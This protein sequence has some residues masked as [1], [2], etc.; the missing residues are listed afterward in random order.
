MLRCCQHAENNFAWI[1]FKRERPVNAGGSRGDSA[2]S[3]ISASGSRDENVTSKISAGGSGVDSI[4]SK[5][6]RM[7]KDVREVKH[8]EVG[9]QRKQFYDPVLDETAGKTKDLSR[10][11]SDIVGGC[12]TL[13]RFKIWT[14]TRPWLSLKNNLITCSYCS[15]VLQLGVFKDPGQRIDPAFINGIKAKT[16]KKLNDKIGDHSRAKTHV[17][18]ESIII[19]SREKRAIENSLAISQVMAKAQTDEKIVITTRVMRTAYEVCKSI[20][21]FKEHS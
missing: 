3:A 7:C 21:S 11:N 10:P 17:K 2:T 14:K 9:E 19:Q 18:C 1:F 16:A 4:P 13:D 6:P 8:I 12:V 5:I 15:D 20:M